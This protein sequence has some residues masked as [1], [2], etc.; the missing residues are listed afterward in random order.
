MSTL[1]LVLAAAVILMLP[2]VGAAQQS[3]TKENQQGAIVLG[4]SA[5]GN[6]LADRK[7]VLPTTEEL[8]KRGPKV[9][10]N[11]A[12]EEM[13]MVRLP[14]RVTTGLTTLEFTASGTMA[15]MGADG[16]WSDYR[17]TKLI[18]GMDFVIP[19]C[20]MEMEL[21]GPGIRKQ[22]EIRVAAGKQAWN[23]EKPGI[24]GTPMPD[25][26]AVER[27]RLIWLI[28]QGAMWAAM[29]AGDKAVLSNE[30]GRLAISYSIDDE[31][32]KVLLNAQLQ[33]E[34]IE[35][36]AHSSTY[37]NTVF[38][39]SYMGYKDYEG[40]LVPFPTRMT[41]KAGGRTILDLDIKSQISNPY[42]IFPRPSTMRSETAVKPR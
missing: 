14:Q 8:I 40:Y 9:A 5:P 25:T 19:A 39:A 42:V 27:E 41:Y 24:D 33:P 37:G 28:P 3:S 4:P 21:V 13:G 23:E 12:A 26:A 10:V 34:R 1:R 18:S 32:V 17:V 35:M 15:E 36:Q 31:P 6:T 16:K 38:A 29:L 30:G 7:T 2:S 20:R 22:R 11:I